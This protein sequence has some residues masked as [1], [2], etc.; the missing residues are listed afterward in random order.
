MSIRPQL[1]VVS[2]STEGTPTKS[3]LYSAPLPESDTELFERFAPYVARI[4][5]R[6]LGREADV[7]D[8]IQDVFIAALRQ[9]HQVRAPE[10]FR[11]WLAIIAVRTARR[12]LRKRRLRAMVGLDTLP[13]SLELRDPS[14][15]P[16]RRALLSRVYVALDRIP[17]DQRI[18]WTL[19][20]VEGEKLEDVAERCGCSLATAKRRIAAAHGRLEAELH[21]G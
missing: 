5:L 18:A 15:S 9:R 12:Y 8:L 21:D 11:S 20:Y 13:P 4:G 17:V 10:A 16:E 2:G 7:D 6:L 19:R 14:I 1:R 3:E